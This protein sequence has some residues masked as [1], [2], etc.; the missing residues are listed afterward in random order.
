MMVNYECKISIS[1][2]SLYICSGLGTFM[3]IPKAQGRGHSYIGKV[4]S[5]L[6][7]IIHGVSYRTRD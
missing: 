5:A 6:T 2:L 4:V 3:E 7:G 1:P